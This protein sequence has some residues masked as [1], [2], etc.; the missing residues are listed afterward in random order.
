MA[1]LLL[2]VIYISFIGLGIP[3]SIFGTAWPA[4]Y[5]EFGVSSSY[6]GYVTVVISGSTMLS[7]L[8][9]AKVINRFGTATV[10][11]VST[12]LTALAMLGFSISRNILCLCFLAVP[13]GLGAGAVDAGLNNYVAL[14]YKAKHMNFLHFFYGIGVTLSPY[15]MSLAL[16]G[17]KGWRGGYKTMFLFQA[18]IAI[19]TIVSIPL[20]KKVNNSK[21]VEEHG[22]QITLS[23]RK[24]VKM[25]NLRLSWLVFI[26]S[27]A[28][29]YVI[30]IWGSTFFV[31][32]KGL[33][34]DH[35]ARCTMLYYAGIAAGRFL[36]GTLS[37]K[38]SCWKLVH[39]GKYIILFAIIMFILPLPEV[40]LPIV[41][42]IA[43]VGMGPI[44]P[45]LLHLTPENF[46]R[47]ISQSVIGTQMVASY[48]GIMLMPALFGVI[49][50]ALGMKI[51]PLFLLIMFV[52]MYWGMN[53][54]LRGI[55]ANNDSC[56]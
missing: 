35:A 19:V 51:F 25:P 21:D 8:L 44:F 43:G 27:C 7:S 31:E 5:N 55:R 4:I 18:F 53:L 33:A 40:I 14:N 46:G 3:D 11:A 17:D 26:S 1:T 39:I 16:A 48:A 56:K 47:E 13:Y 30:G 36:S 9:C 49:E 22:E 23:I 28:I 41:M 32:A 42:F 54:L 6:A 10:T 52:I 15:I 45:N 12:V 29:E 34:A 2:I 38:L 50:G 37:E 24:M 20:W